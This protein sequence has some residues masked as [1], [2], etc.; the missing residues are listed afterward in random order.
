MIGWSKTGRG[1]LW[2]RRCRVQQLV[3]VVISK[4]Y[5]LCLS[6]L[7]E[8]AGLSDTNKAAQFSLNSAAVRAALEGRLSDREGGANDEGAASTI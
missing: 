6:L 7:R 5:S 8:R 3:R 2:R 1:R 4:A